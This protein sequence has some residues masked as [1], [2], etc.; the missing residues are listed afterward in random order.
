MMRKA[1]SCMKKDMDLVKFLQRQ[2]LSSF[3]S[4]ATL[5]GRQY[6]VADKMAS[7]IIRESSDLDASTD[8]YEF[9]LK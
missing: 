3:T 8:D 4:L 2:R 9:K 1:D 6:F 5:D 7:M